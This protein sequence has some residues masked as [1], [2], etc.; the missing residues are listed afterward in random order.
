[1]NVKTDPVVD[2]RSA[3]QYFDRRRVNFVFSDIDGI[4]LIRGDIKD[5]F[6]CQI[7]SITHYVE[8]TYK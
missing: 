6:K 3:V 7:R 2:S 4:N 1:M 5:G 8:D